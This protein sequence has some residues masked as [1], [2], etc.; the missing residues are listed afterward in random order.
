M[1]AQ[2]AHERTLLV[3]FAPEA[4]LGAPYARRIVVQAGLA[5][6]E[7]DKLSGEELE[8][9]GLDL[10]LGT[11][12]GQPTS[13]VD[14][15][16]EVHTAWI[17]EGPNATA[18]MKALRAGRRVLAL[19]AR[20]HPDMAI[21]VLFPS[22]AISQTSPAAAVA[23][24]PF[25]PAQAPPP[26]KPFA[27]SNAAFRIQ[28]ESP[29]A[30]DAERKLSPAIERALAEV[31]ARE[32][33]QRLRK[34]SRSSRASSQGTSSPLAS[35]DP[36]G[37]GSVPE[38]RVFSL[39][40]PSPELAVEGRHDVEEEDV[41]ALTAGSADVT[42]TIA[43]PEQLAQEPN[44]CASPA[45]SRASSVVSDR[46]AGASLHSS[47]A[48]TS[49][50]AR[51]APSSTSK[52]AIQPRLT[53]AAALRLGL[54]LP[55]PT[56]RRS[57]VQALAAPATPAASAATP[58]SLAAPAITPRMSKAAALRLGKAEPPASTA[59]TT[60]RVRQSISTAERAAM[61]RARRQSA[62]ATV[63]DNP[64]AATPK[65]RV[66]VR[67][68]RAALLREGLDVKAEQTRFA[69]PAGR[70]SLSAS[71][72]GPV[73]VTSPTA[74]AA[75]GR[76]SLVSADLK[77][78]REP[79]VAPRMTKAASLRASMVGTGARPSLSSSFGGN[80]TRPI[81]SRPA[82]AASLSSSVS[83][84][85]SSTTSASIPGPVQPRR[86]VSVAATAPPTLAPR[87]NKAAELRRAMMTANTVSTP[88][89][90]VNVKKAGTNGPIRRKAFGE[91]N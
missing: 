41:Q 78:L 29:P 65:P 83:R 28:P 24:A 31:E 17:V 55:P 50:R 58:R 33:Q 22:L 10:G 89:A 21:E 68:S 8:E 54:A 61:D 70:A 52:P 91:H 14:A 12:D 37:P 51:P 82:S 20:H 53:K 81:S 7:E 9:A 74:T 72:S 69:K 66:E 45:R 75:G 30:V 13:D 19:T 47:T 57:T 5:V 27:L 4:T 59:T 39:R 23:S 71:T 60:P 35:R 84:A 86:S 16:T 18:A 11:G 76:R 26:P 36:S 73:Q 46:S 38:P 42:P 80:P 44:A 25:P 32:E 2:A 88:D 3:L 43:V 15:S 67:M 6:F 87:L 48:S 56:P 40:T 34:I 85:P 62:A 79:S 64:P 90:S 49:F 77:A 63:G 1:T